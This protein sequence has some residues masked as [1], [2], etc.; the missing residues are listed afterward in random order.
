MCCRGVV[1][2]SHL[3]FSNIEL[4]YLIVYIP[5]PVLDTGDSVVKF[6]TC[7]PERYKPLPYARHK[8]L[9]LDLQLELLDDYRI[10]LLQVKKEEGNDP[11]GARYGAILNSVNYVLDVLQQWRELVVSSCTTVSNVMVTMFMLPR[12]YWFI[13]PCL[14]MGSCWFTC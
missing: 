8:L 1:I 12:S 4:L 3:H 5:C 7:P 13:C 14:F 6:L 9:F 11:L 10:R 2:I